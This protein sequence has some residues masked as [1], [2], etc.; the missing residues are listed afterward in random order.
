M[1]CGMSDEYSFYK[2]RVAG[3]TY[4]SKRFSER[5]GDITSRPMRYITKVLDSPQRDEL[6]V[7]GTELVIRRTSGGREELKALFY[8]DDRSIRRLILSKFSTKT[9]KPIKAQFSFEHEELRKFLQ[10]LESIVRVRLDMGNRVRFDDA[11]VDELLSEDDD[12]IAFLR[13]NRERLASLDT[14]EWMGF[15]EYASRVK[16]LKE[17][18]ALLFDD[19]YFSDQLAR[20]NVT[21]AEALWQRFFQRNP[22]IF[23]FG[24]T[25]IFLETFDYRRLEQVVAGSDITSRGKR[26]DALMRTKGVLGALCFIEIK[27]HTTPLIATHKPYRPDTW[28]VSDELSGAVSQCHK[29][30]QRALEKL[31]TKVSLTDDHGWP[32]STEGYLIRLEVFLSSVA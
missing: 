3:R 22:W 2:N 18:E 32:T 29:T 17:F 5:E 7:R 6:E 14:S 30:V 28:R 26:V 15:I 24:L 12:L 13:R 21:G 11:F 25:P 10:F 23:G 31:G 27:T 9:G 4:W 20:Q 1:G 16:E 8:E 19:E